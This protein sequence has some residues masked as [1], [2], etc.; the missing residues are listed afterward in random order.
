MKIEP[1]YTKYAILRALVNQ[2]F[3]TFFD[4]IYNFT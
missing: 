3:D 1:I 4:N 2:E